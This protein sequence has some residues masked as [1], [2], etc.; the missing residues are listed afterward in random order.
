MRLKYFNYDPAW[1]YMRMYYEK[2]GLGSASS[3]EG[4]YS[5]NVAM[6]NWMK[7]NG[8]KYSGQLK[9]MIG[10]A[11][12]ESFFLGRADDHVLA[13]EDWLLASD[14]VSQLIDFAHTKHNTSAIRGVTYT[15]NS[16]NNV[17]FNFNLPNVTDSQSF[18]K[19]IQTDKKVQQA[20]QSVTIGRAM[21]G[22]SLDV[23]RFK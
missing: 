13:K 1:N 16:D 10:K 14:M 21:N 7:S 2:M 18:L 6:L 20:L 3:Y 4:T 11:G 8:F 15:D 19:A 22:N 12:E 5:Q 17:T 23:N 9:S